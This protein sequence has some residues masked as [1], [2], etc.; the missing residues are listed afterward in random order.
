MDMDGDM[1]QNQG[2]CTRLQ[3]LSKQTHTVVPRDPNQYNTLGCVKVG[4]WLFSNSQ[5]RKQ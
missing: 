3:S 2:H 4:F 5:I 1:G